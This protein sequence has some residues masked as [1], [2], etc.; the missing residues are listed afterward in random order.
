MKGKV[1]IGM[2][3]AVVLFMGVPAFAQKAEDVQK[4]ASCKYCGMDR[5]KFNY[6][7]MLI[8]YNDGSELASCSIHC[9][10]LDLALNLGKSPTS[11]QVADYN[12]KKLIDAEKAA[13]VIGGKKPGVMTKVAKWAFEKQEDALAFIKENE[14]KAAAFDDAMRATFEDMYGDVKM[15]RAKREKMKEMK[16]KGQEE[17]KHH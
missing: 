7:R 11:L 13:W 3:I 16:M 12:T 14:G 15:I 1:F 4:H 5:E 9:A 2:M 8:T 10:A 17:K 6:S